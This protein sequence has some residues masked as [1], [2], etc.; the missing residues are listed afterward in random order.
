MNININ[1]KIRDALKLPSGNTVVVDGLSRDEVSVSYKNPAKGVRGGF[2]CKRH[3]L[4]KYAETAM[5]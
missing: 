4:I 1:I 2:T 3:W 5:V